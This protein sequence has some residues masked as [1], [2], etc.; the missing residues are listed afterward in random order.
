M[1][2]GA[3]QPHPGRVGVHPEHGPGLRRRQPVATDQVEQFPV[4]RPQG[5]HRGR[6]PAAR[7]VPRRS[8]RR[9][10]RPRQ[11]PA[12]ELPQAMDQP[13]PARKGGT[14]VRQHPP[15]TPNSDGR[16]HR[17]P[18]VNSR[19]RTKRAEERFADHVGDVTGAGASR[20]GVTKHPLLV[21]AIET[22][23]R[24]GVSPGRRRQQVR[25]GLFHARYLP[26]V[27]Q[28]FQPFPVTGVLV[29]MADV[30]HATAPQTGAGTGGRLV[31]ARRRSP[32]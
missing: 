9:P 29:G 11:D 27:G 4:F 2:P 28:A 10:P 13:L 20:D 3:R 32:G 31:S 15:A 14:L 30:G 17:S 18:S 5:R 21:T 23:E 12:T 6:Q 24:L 16:R 22:A 26:A 1:R 7:A 8:R 19:R 25:V